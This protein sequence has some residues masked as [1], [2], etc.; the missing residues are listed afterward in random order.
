M[1]LLM[2]KTE[3]HAGTQSRVIRD[4]H[5]CLGPLPHSLSAGTIH[6]AAQDTPQKAMHA[7]PSPETGAN[8]N[9][10]PDTSCCATKPG[11]GSLCRVDRACLAAALGAVWGRQPHSTWRQLGIT[12][13]QGLS[14]LH[15]QLTPCCLYGGGSTSEELPQRAARRGHSSSSH[16]PHNSPTTEPR[17]CTWRW[18]YTSPVRPAVGCFCKTT[19]TRGATFSMTPRHLCF[20]AWPPCAAFWQQSVLGASLAFAHRLQASALGRCAAQP[21]TS[22]R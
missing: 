21:H 16:T 15:P 13:D 6:G 1:G 3:Q 20:L 8:P 17:G 7:V 5:P 12:G 2:G 14:A 18:S 10:A 11:Q 4:A 22:R 9:A 19:G